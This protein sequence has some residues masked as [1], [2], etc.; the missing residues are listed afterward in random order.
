MVGEPALHPGRLG[1]AEGSLCG[2]APATV[3]MVKNAERAVHLFKHFKWYVGDRAAA[4]AGV[5]EFWKWCRQQA[6]FAKVHDQAAR[7]QRKV[8]P[9]V[10]VDA[11]VGIDLR[12]CC[13]AARCNTY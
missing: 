12:N 9:A 6:P 10:I 11:P 4:F 8:I 7:Q 3:E 5:E 13:R 2:G 1:R